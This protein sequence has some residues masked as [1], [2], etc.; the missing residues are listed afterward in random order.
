MEKILSWDN[1]LKTGAFRFERL[2]L[3]DIDNAPVIMI[4]APDIIDQ[5][6]CLFHR[7]VR[8]GDDYF[9]ILHDAII[10]GLSE[11]KAVPVVR[12]ADGEY[13]YYNYDLNCNGL[14]Q[15]AES[16]RAIK[17]AMPLHIGAL[18]KL[19]RAGKLA[20]LVFPG[21]TAR[22]SK[23]LFSLL[24]SSKKDPSAS[25]FLELLF[26]NGI[27]LTADNYMP[28]YVVYAYLTSEDFIRLVD[29]K[30]V[31]ILNSDFN[32]ESCTNW[33]ARFSSRPDLSF[34]ETPAEYVA[35]RWEAM[36]EGILKQISPDADLCI[37]GAGIGSL[38]VCVDVAERFSI[39]AI[40]AGHVLNIMNDRVDKSNGARLYTIRKTN[41]TA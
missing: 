26:D 29:S 34:V 12:F 38:T 11:R 33:F 15:Q 17:K 13:A 40:D 19:A 3:K 35:T 30:K 10:R 25:T 27:E 8:T 14:Y 2:V 23:G 39:P 41:A 4:N 5:E 21:N 31:C 16:V 18:K 6:T 9:M 1:L 36:K 28:F 37:V 24:R 32:K 22:K 7:D 20:P